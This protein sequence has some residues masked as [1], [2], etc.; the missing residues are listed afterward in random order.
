M[1]PIEAD[2]VGTSV[3][4]GGVAPLGVHS[5]KFSM[6]MFIIS[7]ALTFTA[8]LVAYSYLR[9]SSKEWPL[10]F[11]FFPSIVVSTVMTLFL[12]TS[13]I[14]MVFAVAAA[15]QGRIEAAFKWHLDLDHSYVDGLVGEPAER[16]CGTGLEVTGA[17]PDHALEVGNRC[18]L[19]GERL[20]AFYTDPALQPSDI[21]ERLCQGELPRLWI[22]KRE[23][24]RFL[25]AIPTLGT[26]K[27]DL[28]RVKSLAT[29]L[30]A[31]TAV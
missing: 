12:L 23:D 3:W 27:T 4:D 24:I 5:K 25:E 16:R 21:W 26:G 11:H 10:A 28:K 29:E 13:S 2:G 30:V 18:D 19:R 17:H 8:L 20:V 15:Q 6:W 14:T 22:P 7:D 9:V 31:P 1:S